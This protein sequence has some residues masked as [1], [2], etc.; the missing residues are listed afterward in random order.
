VAQ[1]KSPQKSFKYALASGRS[2]NTVHRQ[3]GAAVQSWH[4]GILAIL[5]KGV[6]HLA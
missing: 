4:L 5:L 6:F 1:K 2:L 3:N